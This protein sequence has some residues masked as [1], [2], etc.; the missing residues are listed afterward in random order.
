[1]S[2]KYRMVSD[3]AKMLAGAA[4]WFLFDLPLAWLLGPAMIGLIMATRDQPIGTDYFFG[5][6]GRG[7]LGVAIGASITQQHID[8]MLN[9]PDLGIGL[10][11]YVALGGGIGFLWLHRFCNWDRPSA[12]FAAFPGGMS[13][14]IASAEA[15]GANIP[16]VAL[17]HSL[18]IFCLVCGA[19]LAS[20]FVAGVTTGSLS[21]GAVS[22]SIQPLV[23]VTV[24]GA[25]WGGKRLKM[26][27]PSFMAPLFASL[28][29]NFFFD[30]Q[31]ILTDIVLIL[32][33][34]FLGWSIASRFK[35]V[36]KKEVIEILKQVFVLLLLFVPVWGAMAVLLDRFT[37]IDLTSIILGLAPGGQAE[38][39][40]IAIAL[41]ANLAV[42]MVLH[43]FRSLII[44]ML[45]PIAYGLITKSK[46]NRPSNV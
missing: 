38:I 46:R 41:D 34:Y 44:T 2:D 17:S 10:L 35:G 19:S 23:F 31:L 20:F 27:A 42:V 32:G 16:K 28:M 6:F 43:V 37:D 13:E 24:V 8:W 9:H 45:G 11:I 36:S 5:D 22:W 4:V 1:M 29:I 25:V 14:M 33:Q 21:F 15:F 12:W 26:P 30:I 40:L 39:A 18:R 7:L 3:H